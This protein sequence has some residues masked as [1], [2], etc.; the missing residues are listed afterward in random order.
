MIESRT[1][2]CRVLLAPCDIFWQ[3]KLL[4]DLA[5]HDFLLRYVLRDVNFHPSRNAH[6]FNDNLQVKEGG[7]KVNAKRGSDRCV[8]H[9]VTGIHR[10]Q[11]TPAFVI[12]IVRV[13]VA[14]VAG[15]DL[16]R[17]N[18]SKEDLLFREACCSDDNRADADIDNKTSIN[19]RRPW[20]DANSLL[21]D[22]LRFSKIVYFLDMAD[23]ECSCRFARPE[24]IARIG[25]ISCTETDSVTGEW[26]RGIPLAEKCD[27]RGIHT[28]GEEDAKRL[29]RDPFLD[30][31]DDSVAKFRLILCLVRRLVT[32]C[33]DVLL[34]LL[35]RNELSIPDDLAPDCHGIPHARRCSI[36]ACQARS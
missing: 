23:V 1:V 28:A 30:C 18:A 32:Q 11:A 21:D 7:E 27:K 29:I 17:T 9:E 14:L 16:F 26:N 34:P 35:L 20:K 31:D 5:K 19:H 3:T 15:E 8:A 13:R 36:P 33:R 6:R 4:C 24:S 12:D 2:L 22:S 10:R 25:H